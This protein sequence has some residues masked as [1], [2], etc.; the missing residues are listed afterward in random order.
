VDCELLWIYLSGARFEFGA[1]RNLPTQLEVRL[2]RATAN[3]HRSYTN[4]SVCL[5]KA[6]NPRQQLMPRVNQQNVW[7]DGRGGHGR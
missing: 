4:N 5:G 6:W 3:A 1:A 7:L 2:Q